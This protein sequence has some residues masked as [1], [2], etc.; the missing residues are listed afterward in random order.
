MLLSRLNQAL[1]LTARVRDI[2]ERQH[3]L[4]AA[5]DWSDA[6]LD[7]EQRDAFHSLAVPVGG[8]DLA[9]AEAL[10]GARAAEQVESLVDKSL[11]VVQTTAASTRFG[12]LDTIRAYALERLQADGTEADARTRHAHYFA[13]FAATTAERLRGPQQREAIQSLQRER[14]NLNAAFAW[15]LDTR[16]TQRPVS[17]GGALWPYWAI[18]GELREGAAW[19]ARALQD[20][21]SLTGRARGDALLVTAVA[22]LQGGDMHNGLPSLNEALALYDAA[23][24]DRGAAYALLFLG[25]TD[26]SQHRF[27]H[28]GD[29]SGEAF[30][31]A[32]AAE[33]R[34]IED[35]PDDAEVLYRAA[36]SRAEAAEDARACAQALNGLGLIELLRGRA[37]PA[38]PVL[39]SSARLCLDLDHEAGVWFPLMSRV[40]RNE[41]RTVCAVRRVIISPTQSGDTR[42]R[43]LGYQLTRDRKINGT[44]A[45]WKKGATAGRRCT[46]GCVRPGRHGEGLI[47]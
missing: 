42:R 2:P 18:T 38:E 40:T 26:E 44:R 12:M 15:L 19:M 5:I 35:K 31:L 10:L 34:V 43:C 25:R 46:A 29:L 30:A 17:T 22:A 16:D 32:T 13:Q 24:D 3:S 14:E 27:E 21:G 20:D 47:A 28:A 36:L 39:L 45:C 9:A 37:Q 11:L 23:G 33:Y 6:L 41:S 1:D 8:L 7:S 4:R